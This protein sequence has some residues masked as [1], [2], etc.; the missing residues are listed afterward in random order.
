VGWDNF[1][2]EE[3]TGLGDAQQTNNRC[4]VGVLNIESV[5]E[6]QKCKTAIKMR[7]H[8]GRQMERNQG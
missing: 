3:M 8:S 4:S 5:A 1:K 2:F 6:I 7:S